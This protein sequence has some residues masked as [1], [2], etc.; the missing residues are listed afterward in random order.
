MDGFCTNER[1]F[2]PCQE[3]KSLYLLLPVKS[4]NMAWGDV[5]GRKGDCTDFELVSDEM[6]IL[7]VQLSI[8]CHTQLRPWNGNSMTT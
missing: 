8:F 4:F 6:E 2:S 5:L 7:D 1:P 3:H